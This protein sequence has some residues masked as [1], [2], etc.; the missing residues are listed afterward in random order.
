MMW[1]SAL[2]LACL[3]SAAYAELPLGGD[4]SVSSNNGNGKPNDLLDPNFIPQLDDKNCWTSQKEWYPWFR[5]SYK[6]IQTFDSITLRTGHVNGGALLAGFKVKVSDGNK[7]FRL[8]GVKGGMDLDRKKHYK[9]CGKITHELGDGEKVTLTCNSPLEGKDIYIYRPVKEH[10]TMRIC[11]LFD[12]GPMDI[13]DAEARMSTNTAETKPGALLL[14]SFHAEAD[15]SNCALSIKEKYPWY[16]IQFDHP[17]TIRAVKVLAGKV[18][19]G[20]H[21]GSLMVKLGDGSDKTILEG[22]LNG[23][24]FV[25]DD[26]W[27]EC[28]TYEGTIEDG[29]EVTIHCK[30]PVTGKILYILRNI[31]FKGQMKVCGVKL[32]A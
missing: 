30:A 1:P 8:G 27:T 13:Q 21:L 32:V 25:R 11:G 18:N 9:L 7:K 16:S 12:M 23:V 10:I 4:A 24:S 19:G 6:D 14:P 28:G 2:L 3:L 26:F 20:K 31:D 5:I 17:T 22:H 15:D 29:Q